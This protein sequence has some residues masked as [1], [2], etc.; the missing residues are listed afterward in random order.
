MP[1]GRDT[2][3]GAKAAGTVM[4]NSL[5]IARFTILEVRR[6]R[7]AV[8]V[9]CVLATA[10]VLA[11]FLG[12][13]AITDVEQVQAVIIAALERLC[14]VFLLTSLVVTGV[15]READDRVIELLLAHPVRR[16]SYVAGK[17]IGYGAIALVLAV[18]LALPLLA[19][20]P[21]ARVACW[22]ASLAA[23]LMMMVAAALFC[24]LSLRSA[25]ASLAAV[26]GFYALGRSLDA[27]MLIA[28]ASPQSRSW[29]DLAARWTTEALGLVLP[30]IDR[31]TASAWLAAPAL[32][33]AA[34]GWALLGA[35][36]YTLLLIAAAFFDF[37]RQSF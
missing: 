14:A 17:A 7:L 11:A 5:T 1:E 18:A 33:P 3:P 22:S 10:V 26:A 29:T 20:A 2:L 8:L 16:P 30:H 19:L 37:A 21:P 6:G 35:G 13:V 36:V 12:Q 24:A 34:V 15:R 31:M 27:I 23:E 28:S 32:E 25:T 4:L 9:L